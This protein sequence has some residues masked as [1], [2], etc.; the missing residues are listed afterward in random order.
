MKERMKSQNQ[1]FIFVTDTKGQ[2][3]YANDKYCQI[4]GYQN[5]ELLKTNIKDLTHHK[6]Q[7]TTCQEIQW[8][9]AG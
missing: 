2:I 8:E 9:Q 5:S 6:M 7:S 4:T 1:Q 3:T